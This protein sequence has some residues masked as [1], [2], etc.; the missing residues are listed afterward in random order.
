MK[1]LSWMAFYPFSFSAV[2]RDLQSE[3]T[4][5]TEPQH[6]VAEIL[7]IIKQLYVFDLLL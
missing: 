5:G 3:V 7:I 1:V 4:T 2:I 6:S